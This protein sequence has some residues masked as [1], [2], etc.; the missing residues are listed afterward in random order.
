MMNIWLS[1]D[2]T[3]EEIALVSE[4]TLNQDPGEVS[5]NTKAHVLIR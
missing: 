5:N 4:T 1:M 2:K 3:V